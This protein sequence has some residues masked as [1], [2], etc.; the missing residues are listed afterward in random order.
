MS[1]DK[2]K[3]REDHHRPTAFQDTDLNEEHIAS[4]KTDMIAM[5]RPFICDPG[6]GKKI[7]EAGGEE[8][9][10][11]IMCNKCHGSSPLTGPWFGVCSVNP[12]LGIESTLKVIDAAALSKKVAVIGGGPAGMKA[13]ITAAEGHK[14]T[15]YEKN[16]FLGGLLQHSDFSRSNGRSKTSRITLFVKLKKQGSR[17]F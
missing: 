11:C 12:K 7:N 13:A 9:V 1:L 3:R 2:G 5:A 10:P 16:A 17:C 14:V 4:G 8:T 6:Y 15:L